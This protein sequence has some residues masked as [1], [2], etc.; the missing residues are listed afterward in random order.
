MATNFLISFLGLFLVVSPSPGQ[1][2]PATVAEQYQTLLKEYQRASGSGP[3]TDE[4]RIRHIGEVYRKRAGIALKMVELAEKHP[5]DPV[6]I[7][8]LAQAVWQVNT[9]PWPMDVTGDDPAR[10]RALALLVRDHLASEKLAE[11]CQ[12]VSHGFCQEY[13]TFLRA[14]L[15]GSPHQTVRGQACFCLAHYLINRAQRIE[16]TREQPEEAKVFAGLFGKDYLKDLLQQDRSLTIAA[17]ESLFERA[18]KEFGSVKYDRSTVGE[19]ARAALFELRHLSIGK[20]A[21]DI[22]GQD[23][24]GKRFA[25]SDYRG[26][27]VLQDFWHQQ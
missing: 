16:L 11:V 22:E 23:Q 1:E 8:A 17:A 6:A 10:P 7:Q 24:D 26:K 25:L 14:V 21:P 3:V 2:K 5:G 4:N 9:N 13:E 15:Q 27:V 19:K 18:D 12:R 20:T